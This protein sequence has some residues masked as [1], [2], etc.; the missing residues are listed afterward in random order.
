[1]EFSGLQE[2]GRAIGEVLLARTLMA[3]GEL[4]TAI[5]LLREAAA[6]LA[7]TGYSWGPLALM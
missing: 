4:A 2:P 5:A 1:M 7:Q 6:A 3:S